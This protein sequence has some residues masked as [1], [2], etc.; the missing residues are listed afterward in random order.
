MTVFSGLD[1][2][3]NENWR[4]VLQSGALLKGLL[5]FLFLNHGTHI[6]MRV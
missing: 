3:L 5:V 1:L 6:N 4:V 2:V